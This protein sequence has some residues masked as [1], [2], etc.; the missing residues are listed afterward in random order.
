MT[1]MPRAL[2]SACGSDSLMGTGV[3]SRL[4]PCLDRVQQQLIWKAQ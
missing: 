3:L 2:D 4:N 1:V